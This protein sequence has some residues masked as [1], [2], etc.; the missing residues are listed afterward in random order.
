M[1]NDAEPARKVARD[2]LKDGVEA[3]SGLSMD[4]VRVQRNMA[5]PAK[6]GARADPQEQHLPHEAWHVVQ[7]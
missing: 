1:P 7:S 2:R 4:D 5:A 6:L 3:L